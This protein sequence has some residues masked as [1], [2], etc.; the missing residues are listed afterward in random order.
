[1][2]PSR[3]RAD[4]TSAPMAHG[5]VHAPQGRGAALDA[6][7]ADSRWRMWIALA[8]NVGMLA[9]GIGGGILTGS[10]ALL[11]DAGHVLSDV[12]A[13][14]LG[15]VAGGLAARPSGPRLSLIHI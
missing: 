9:I 2:R 8:I 12:G 3:E 11:A 14:A 15:L 6:R 4:L 13:I 1:M 7:R 5:H 10:L